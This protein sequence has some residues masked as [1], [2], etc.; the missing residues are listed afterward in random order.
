M[1]FLCHLIF[2]NSIINDADIGFEVEEGEFC[3]FWIRII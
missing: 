3:V 2:F 1:N